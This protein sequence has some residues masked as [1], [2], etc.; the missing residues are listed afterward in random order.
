M[1]HYS[2]DT[3]CGI[4][5]LLPAILKNWRRAGLISAPSSDKGYSSGQ[6][7]RIFSVLEMTDS[8]DTLS[9]VHQRL[10]SAAYISRSGWACRQEELTQQ[11]RIASDNLL[12]KRLQQVGNDYSSEAFVNDYLRPLNL[13]LRSDVSE[14][15]NERQTRFH[16][17]VM[18]H[19]QRTMSAAF[20]RKSIP[21]FLEA[22]SVN[23]ATEIWMESIRLV[24]QGF[25]VEV[26]SEAKGVPATASYRHAHHLMWCGAGISQLMQWNYR[27]KLKDGIPA[28]LCGPNQ[29]LLQAAA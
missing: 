12:Q 26:A 11:L 23:D 17:A 10:Y 4:T 6:L 18:H 22:V 9:E 1:P 20:R 21:L 3:V 27:H 13:W 24:G 19:A 5:G 2:T 14:G 15:A 7:T 25:R 16:A 29:T 8:G 28:L